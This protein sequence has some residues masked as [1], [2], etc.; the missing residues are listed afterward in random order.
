ML[1]EGSLV[2]VVIVEYVLQG[3]VVGRL[4]QCT[5]VGGF[6]WWV[7]V[8]V[9]ECF[10]L[11]W[12]GGEWPLNLLRHLLLLQQLGLVG[13]IGCGALVEYLFWVLLVLLQII[14]H[15]FGHNRLHGGLLGCLLLLD[16]L[17]V[18]GSRLTGINVVVGGANVLQHRLGGKVITLRSIDALIFLLG[19]CGE[20]LFR[21]THPTENVGLTFLL[22]GCGVHE[23]QAFSLLLGL[24]GL[25]S[26]IH[27]LQLLG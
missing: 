27:H 15:N 6:D 13:S 16:R 3:L 26:E 19:L 22:I 10:S 12:V 23:I 9:V 18:A 4:T 1:V 7:L 5:L 11:I 21:R 2:G 17:L 25:S 20:D 8:Y 24:Q 14:V